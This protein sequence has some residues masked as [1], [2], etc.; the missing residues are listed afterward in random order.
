MTS[1]ASPEAPVTSTRAETTA[2]GSGPGAGPR[3]RASRAAEASPASSLRPLVIDIAVPLGLYYLVRN[4]FGASVVMSLAVASIGPA[5]RAIAS[6]ARDRR[7][8]MLAGLML[9]VN[10]V[11]IGIS[12]A[13]GDPRMMMAKDSAVSSVIGLTILVS[14]LAG[15]PLM[16]AGLKPFVTKGSPGKAAAWDRLAAGSPRFGRLE[17]LFSVIWGTVL[18]ADC[19]ARIVGAFTLPV[20]TMVWLSTVFVIGAIALGVLVGGLA[21]APIEEMVRAEARTS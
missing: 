18:L 11:G 17:K 2:S 10:V 20:T 4:G 15:R 8:N 9:A 5:A 16:S 14:V 6:I 19:A 7:L 3:T 21:A 1:A 12:F 13:A